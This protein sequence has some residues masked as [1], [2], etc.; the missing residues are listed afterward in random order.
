ML[1]KLERLNIY[2]WLMMLVVVVTL[3]AVMML[4]NRGKM[5]FVLSVRRMLS[6]LR[7]NSIN[8]DSILVNI[9][10]KLYYIVVLTIIQ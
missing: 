10:E 1:T 8:S 3:V 4:R 2:Y 7:R 5:S 6:V 9:V